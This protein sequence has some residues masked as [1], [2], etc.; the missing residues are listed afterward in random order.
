MV[1]AVLIAENAIGEIGFRTKG[2]VTISLKTVEGEKIE[3]C[4]AEI[5][6]LGINPTAINKKPVVVKGEE[7]VFFYGTVPKG[8][9]LELDTWLTK[10]KVTKKMKE[11]IFSNSG[12]FHNSK[13][14]EYASLGALL[15]YAW[16]NKM[17]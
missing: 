2:M 11:Q 7:L 6:G 5:E 15:C 4:V 16:L 12:V 14:L 1:K 13:E 3:D 10:N 8:V 17:L 9:D